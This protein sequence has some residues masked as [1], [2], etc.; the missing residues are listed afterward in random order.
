MK[1][2]KDATNEFSRIALLLDLTD[3][4]ETGSP[5]EKLIA[6]KFGERYIQHGAWDNVHEYRKAWL[7]KEKIELPQIKKEWEDRSKHY[8]K[9]VDLIEE[10]YLK[11]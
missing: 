8:G 5:L 11:N 3:Q 7:C 2:V 9:I 4:N 10:Y 1:L 6:E